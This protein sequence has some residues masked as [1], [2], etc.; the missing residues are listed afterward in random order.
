MIIL[1]TGNG[2][3]KTTS[4]IGQGI[5]VLGQGGKVFMTQF[6]KSH[7][8][9]AGE[10]DILSQTFADRWHFSKGGLGFV[11]ILG[12]K[13]PRSDHAS[14]AA[15]TLATGK[16]ALISGKWQLVILDEINVALSLD[17]IKLSE[18]LD[19]LSDIPE[20]TDV[21]LTGR[22]APDELITRAD[23]VTECQEIKHPYNQGIQGSRS[24]E[25]WTLG[26]RC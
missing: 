13:L 9:P 15:K 23:L 7:T 6:I 5:R 25:F 20:G 1:V 24:H 19:M 10:D 16:A 11:G 26:L 21:I 22:G 18:V 12:D 14:A 3:G 4:A 2:K 17:L 8:F